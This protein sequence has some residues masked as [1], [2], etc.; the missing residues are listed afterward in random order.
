MRHMKISSVE[1]WTENVG[2]TGC[3]EPS[4]EQNTNDDDIK[5]TNIVHF[6]IISD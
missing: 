3:L 4:V 2:E 5:Q 6:T 1:L